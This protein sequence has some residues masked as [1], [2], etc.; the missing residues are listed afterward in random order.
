LIFLSIALIKDDCRSMCSYLIHVYDRPFPVEPVACFRLP[1]L[2]DYTLTEWTVQSAM[3]SMALHRRPRVRRTIDCLAQL[4]LLLTCTDSTPN[5]RSSL[6]DRNHC[7]LTYSLFPYWFR[8]I[9]LKLI[10]RIQ[11]VIQ[12]QQKLHA[13]VDSQIVS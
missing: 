11:R 9:N 3:S 6:C 13:V 4:F 2:H 8:A 12:E 7:L 10:G 1:I 5:C